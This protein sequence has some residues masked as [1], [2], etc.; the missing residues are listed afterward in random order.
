MGKFLTKEDMAIIKWD[1]AVRNS[2]VKRGEYKQSNHT[3]IQICGCGVP[4][5]HFEYDKT[6]Y[7]ENADLRIRK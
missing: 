7:Y 5:C 6:K 3:D 1:Q 2:M 4:G